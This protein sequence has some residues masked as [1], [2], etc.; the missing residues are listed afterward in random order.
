MRENTERP[1][2]VA[3]N[4]NVL[5]GTDPERVMVAAWSMLNRQ[6]GWKNPFGDG[7]AA[8]RILEHAERDGDRFDKH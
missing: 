3:A 4:A 5:A 1:E 6:G 8:A 7:R 2:T